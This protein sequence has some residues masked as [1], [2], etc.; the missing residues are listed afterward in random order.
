MQVQ[1]QVQVQVCAGLCRFV[2]VCY[3]QEQHGFDTYS[4]GTPAGGI[5]GMRLL[6]ITPKPR[7]LQPPP[8]AHQA[9]CARFSLT[10]RYVSI[11]VRARAAQHQCAPVIGFCGGVI[12]PS[13]GCCPTY[14]SG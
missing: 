14:F 13:C 1:V 9:H 6:G 10:G 11:D 8:P 12:P 7:P 3:M 4:A 5:Y 2:Q